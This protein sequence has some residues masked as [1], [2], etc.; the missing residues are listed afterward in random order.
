MV[1]ALQELQLHQQVERQGVPE[2][3]PPY[4]GMT[5]AL[6]QVATHQTQHVLRHTALPFCIPRMQ[7]IP[8]IAIW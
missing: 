3:R 2:L 6:S 8:A 4:A 7:G 5:P 1:W